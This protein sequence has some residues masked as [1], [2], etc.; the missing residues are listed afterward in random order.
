MSDDSF[1]TF[2]ADQLGDLGDVTC[3]AMFGGYGLSRGGAFFGII[4]RGRLYFKTDPTRRAAYLE[5]GMKPFRPNARQTLRSYYEVPPE[6]LEDREQL[7]VW[8]ERAMRSEAPEGAAGRRR[9]SGRLR[10]GRRGSLGGAHRS[11]D[12]SRR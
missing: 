4:S 7:V 10:E 2:V 8:A 3:R 9:G 5:Q 12:R 6:I 11:A 1:K